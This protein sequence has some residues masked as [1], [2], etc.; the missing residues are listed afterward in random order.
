MDDACELY[1]ELEEAE[2][3]EVVGRTTRPAAAAAEYGET[4]GPALSTDGAEAVAVVRW[5]GVETANVAS[6]GR[7]TGC[8]GLKSRSLASNCDAAAKDEAADD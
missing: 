8:G 2:R 4:S 7:V 1:T 6:V 5:G 3:E